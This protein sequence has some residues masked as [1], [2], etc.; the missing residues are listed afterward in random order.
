MTA[1]GLAA[2]L[3]APPTFTNDL[4]FS[5]DEYPWTDLTLVCDER[6]I[7]ML[8]GD[9]QIIANNPGKRITAFTGFVHAKGTECY[10]DQKGLRSAK[11]RFYDCTYDQLYHKPPR[12]LNG[13]D[14]KK[15]KKDYDVVEE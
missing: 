15:M 6:T 8:E 1:A 5:Q 11:A 10:M 12:R 7:W 14:I 13:R 9:E 2:V 4:L 3:S